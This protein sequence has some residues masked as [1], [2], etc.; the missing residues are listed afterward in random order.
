MYQSLR[1]TLAIPLQ[2]QDRKD[3]NMVSVFLAIKFYQIYKVQLPKDGMYTFK[4]G[5]T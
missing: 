5:L 3:A 2:V 4:T 1:R